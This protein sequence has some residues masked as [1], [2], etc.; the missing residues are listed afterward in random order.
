[1]QFSSATPLGFSHRFIQHAGRMFTSTINLA[2]LRTWAYRS[3]DPQRMLARIE[4]DL[5]QDL[6]VLVF[7]EA[8]ADE[9]AKANTYLLNCG[10]PTSTA[11]LLIAAVA[12]AHDL[13]LVTH[14]VSDFRS[15][16]GLRIEDWQA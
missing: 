2:E 8:C 14:N 16:P 10:R 1:M 5:L 12:L 6:Q 4:Q 15:I 9:F 11:D 3:S 13:T 7:D